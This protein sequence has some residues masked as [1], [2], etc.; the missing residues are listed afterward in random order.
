MWNGG[1]ASSFSPNALIKDANNDLYVIGY[2]NNGKPSGVLRIKSGTT[3]F[4]Q[5]YFFDLNDATGKPCLGLFH[6]DNGMTFTVRYSDETAYPF[7]T[8]ANYDPYAAAEIYKIDLAAKTTSG[9][10]STS[11]P[12][13]F[14]SNIFMTKWDNDKIYFSAPA[15]NSNSVYSYRVT[16][17]TVAK[18]FDLSAGSC[19]G[20]TKLN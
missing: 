15:A 17:G 4:D 8:D 11:L 9:N 13:I 18:E 14:G 3:E 5:D 7:D 12:K 19:N 2:A 10:I 1:T 16:D 6:F 20:F